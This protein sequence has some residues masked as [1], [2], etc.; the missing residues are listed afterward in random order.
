V[1]GALVH[2]G[3][4][5]YVSIEATDPRADLVRVMH[6]ELAGPAVG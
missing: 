1:V 6:A 3:R 2:S 4:S 5:G